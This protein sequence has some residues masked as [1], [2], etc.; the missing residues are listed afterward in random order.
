VH[1][2]GA[3]V[4]P[5]RLWE[6]LFAVELRRAVKGGLPVKRNSKDRELGPQ[7]VVGYGAK[8]KCRPF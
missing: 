1:S 7:R 5:R 2:A 6:A 4:G 8:S 3:R